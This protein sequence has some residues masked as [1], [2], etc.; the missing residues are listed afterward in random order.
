MRRREALKRAVTKIGDW[1][2]TLD[3][4]YFGAFNDSEIEHD[5]KYLVWRLPMNAHALRIQEWST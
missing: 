1:L 4:Q 5:P 3:V 2:S